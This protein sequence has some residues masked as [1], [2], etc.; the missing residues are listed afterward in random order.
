MWC[1]YA[2]AHAWSLKE[3]VVYFPLSLSAL[4]HWREGLLLNPDLLMVCGGFCFVV[5]CFQLGREP[6]STRDPVVSAPTYAGVVIAHVFTGSHLV[7]V[8]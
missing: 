1:A 5:V 7:C 6:A 2:G 4:F 8:C 3:S